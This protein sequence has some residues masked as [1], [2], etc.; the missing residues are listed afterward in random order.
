MQY[1]YKFTNAENTALLGKTVTYDLDDKAKINL[2]GMLFVLDEKGRGTVDSIKS[3][4]SSKGAKNV[5]IS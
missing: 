2:Q 5:K 3:S 1:S 4:L